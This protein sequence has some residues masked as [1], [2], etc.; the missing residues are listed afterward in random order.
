MN[1]YQS[2]LLNFLYVFIVVNISLYVFI[3]YTMYGQ[4][5]TSLTAGFIFFLTLRMFIQTT[6]LNLLYNYLNNKIKHI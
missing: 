4:I 6:Q 3:F 2:P 5:E 1:V